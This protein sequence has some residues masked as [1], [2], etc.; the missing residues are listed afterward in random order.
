MKASKQSVRLWIVQALL[1]T[2]FF[3]VLVPLAARAQSS[4]GRDEGKFRGNRPELEVVLRDSS[5]QAL[6]VSAVIKLLRSGTPTGQV[7]TSAGRATFILPSLGDYTV[8]VDAPGF[9][10]QQ[11]DVS[12]TVEVKAEIDVEMSRDATSDMIV[13]GKP[14]LAPKAKE[15]FDKGLQALSQDRMKDAAKYVAEAA[16]LAPGHPDVLYVKGVLYLKQRNWAEA[17]STLEKATQIDPTHARAFA[18]LGMA[19]VDEGK[20]DAAIPPLEKSVELEPGGWEAEFTLARAYY[21]HEQYE[22]ALKASQEA[23]AGSK[24]KAPEIELLVAQSLTAVGRYEDSATALRNFLKNHGNRPEAA[25]AKKWLDRL[26]ASGKI[27]S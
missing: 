27:K 26:T 22:D 20:Y 1:S 9:R 25:T 7:S 24:G 16:K 12:V 19:F 17:Q 4:D 6:R 5:G 8:M 2:A 15:A 18:A 13:P 3:L 10:A 23:L 21:H 11:R 14:L